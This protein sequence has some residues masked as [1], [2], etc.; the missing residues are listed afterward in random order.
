MT[1]DVRRL[2]ALLVVLSLAAGCVARDAA[3]DDVEITPTPAATPVAP[4]ADPSPTPSPAPPPA[5]PP[6]PTPPPA[7]P[8]PATPPTPPDAP[9]DEGRVV[10]NGSYDFSGGGALLPLQATDTFEVPDGY[11]RLVVNVT[12][13]ATAASGPAD[14]ERRVGLAAP[15]EPLAVVDVG[16]D[17][18]NSTGSITRDDVTP[19][20]WTLHYRGKGP[21]VA[22]IVV[23]LFLAEAE[24]M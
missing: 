19:G 21:T 23:R 22:N 3:Q 14:T 17:G 4:P 8:T 6:N 10:F 12:F 9:A 16:N 2:A 20:T 13:V 15:G 5:P 1:P 24:A 11:E 7:T 18:G